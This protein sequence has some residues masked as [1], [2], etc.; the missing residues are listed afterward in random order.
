MNLKLKK[1]IENGNYELALRLINQIIKKENTYENLTLRGI[2][3][4]YLKKFEAAIVDLDIVNQK[5]PG[6]SDILC[7]L[8]IANKGSKNYKKAISYFKD[9]L[10]FNPANLNSLLNLTETFIETYEYEN[11]L[12][13]LKRIIA[14]NPNLERIY[15][16]NAFCY[17]EINRFSLHHDNLIKASQINKNNYENFYHLGFSFIWKN[18]YDKALECFH[19][20]MK[21]NPFFT[22]PLY[23]INKISKFD[24]KSNFF[25]DLKSISI[26]KLSSENRSYLHLTL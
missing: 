19:L 16:L 18:D 2:I 9:S 26:N 23:Q 21:L 22:P 4:L 12:T 8:G 25:K 6:D 24:T 14:I 11:A 15:Q 10:V 17:R 13:I 3:Y 1:Y 20:S 5:N 7:N